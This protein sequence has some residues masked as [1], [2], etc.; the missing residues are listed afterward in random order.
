MKRQRRDFNMR[1]ANANDR[2]RRTLDSS[3]GRLVLTSS[4]ARS[5]YKDAIVKAVQRYKRFGDADREHS[6]GLVEVN[7]RKYFWMIT[8]LDPDF[9]PF[10]NLVGGN[11]ELRIFEA[12]VNGRTGSRKSSLRTEKRRH[13]HTRRRKARRGKQKT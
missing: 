9:A 1:I 8:Y 4:I 13:V 3:Q 10:N 12:E 2:F 5:K 11:I 6:D 7:G